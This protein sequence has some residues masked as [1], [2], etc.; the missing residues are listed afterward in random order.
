MRRWR[1]VFSRTSRTGIWGG[2]VLPELGGK[3]E[4]DRILGP[5]QLR[6]PTNLTRL[7]AMGAPNDGPE[8][9]VLKRAAL[10]RL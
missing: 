6:L 4:K 9:D 2:R 1:N 7:N 5:A 10:R 3:L 8:E